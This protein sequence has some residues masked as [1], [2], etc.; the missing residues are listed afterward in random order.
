MGIADNR[1]TK[2]E[3]V[4]RLRRWHI[5][6]FAQ[7]VMAGRREVLRS[8]G[9][10]RKQAREETWDYVRRAFSEEELQAVGITDMDDLIAEST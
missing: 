9:R 2:A 3:V 4:A 5:W 10:T 6:G 1:E 7:Q 8:Q